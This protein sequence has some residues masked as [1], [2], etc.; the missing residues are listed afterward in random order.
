MSGS[1]PSNAGFNPPPPG[2]VLGHP[3]QLWMLFMTEFWERFCF[4]GLRWML[5]F[6]VV[7]KFYNGDGSGEGPANAVYGLFTAMIYALSIFGGLA[8]DRVLGYQR[9]IL[10]GAVFMVAGFPLLVLDSKQAFFFGLACVI[11]GVSLLKPNISSMVGQLYAPGDERRDRGFTI[12]YMGINAGAFVAPIITGWIAAKYGYLDINSAALKSEGLKTVFVTA[13]LGMVV[14]LVWFWLGR[15]SLGVVGKPP[16]GKE[17]IGAAMPAV[18]GS[19][20]A[21]PVMYFLL[22]QSTAEIKTAADVPAGARVIE[23]LVEAGSDIKIGDPILRYRSDAGDGVINATESGKV[24]AVLT[25]PFPKLAS[26]QVI[27]E[28]S[29]GKIMA[30]DVPKGA[31]VTS[32]ALTVGQSVQAG[33]EL[34]RY[35]AK[36]DKGIET[37]GSVSAPF[38]TQITAV[39]IRFQPEV[40]PGQAV[41]EVKGGGWINYLLIA[42]FVVCLAVLVVE[43]LKDGP[44]QR[45]R[46][47]ALVILFVFNILFWM[48]FEQAGSSFNFL[49]E[50]IVDRN[51]MGLFEFK[52]AWF[53]S[54]NPAAIVLLAPIVTAIWAF[55]AKRNFEPSIPRKFAL[56]LL[57][58]AIGFL[59]LMYALQ[60]LVD[61]R[62]MIPF[63]TLTA[64]YVFQTIG[65]LAISPIGLSMVTKLAPARIVGATMGAWFLS[66]SLGYKLAAEL[67]ERMSGGESGLTVASSLSGFTFSFYLLLGAG[68]LLFLISPLINKLMHGVK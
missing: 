38:A 51:V 26:E 25:V 12:F 3:R 50:K 1:A 28:T 24:A 15:A 14:S 22:T 55:T 67:A 9:A 2:E 17:S 47:I 23:Q 56:G 41:L 45:D 20:L 65:E 4:Y 6:Y 5:V 66:I 54:V 44:I 62:N 13:G 68:I 49:A 35:T 32:Y 31:R 64:C 30:G 33:E 40:Q 10:L 29:Q 21:V 8:A 53:Q 57:G 27:A 59:I 39:P 7:A 18:V 34:L 36:D 63:W 46:V 37:I 58:N 19:L 42:M 52:V 60:H 43:S 61:D 16:T 11:V 48:F